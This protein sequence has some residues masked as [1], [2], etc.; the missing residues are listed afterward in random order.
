MTV[1]TE[2]IVSAEDQSKGA[3]DSVRK[4]AGEMAADVRE[5]L[6]TVA[7]SFGAAASA[8]AVAGAAMIK[9]GIDSAREIDNLSRV[10]GA[11]VEEFQRMAFGAKSLGIEQDKLADIIKDTNDKLGDFLTTG[12]GAAAD[13]FENIAPKV[14]VTAEQFRNLSGPDALQLYY[15]SLQKANLSQQELTFYMEAIASDA[16]ALI[17][18]LKDGGEAMGEQAKQA[19][20]LG[21][22]LTKI[23]V[24]KLKQAG[25]AMDQVQAAFGGFGNQIAVKF[26]PVVTALSEK[27]LQVVR[28][29]GGFGEISQKVFNGVISGVGFVADAAH[30][31]KAVWK[32]IEVAVLFAAEQI[33][34]VWAKV[35][36]SIQNVVNGSIDIVNILIEKANMLP[37]VSL[38]TIQKVDSGFVKTLATIKEETAIAAQNARNEVTKILN[39]PMPSEGIKKWTETAVLVST[40]AAKAAADSAASG[41][42]VGGSAPTGGNAQSGDEDPEITAMQQ[43]IEQLK[44]LK[45]AQLASEM[46]SEQLAYLQRLEMLRVNFENNTIPT[47]EQ[48]HALVEGVA[49][50]HEQNLTKISAK[51]LS[52]REKFLAKSGKD[53]TK[54]VFGDLA[55]ITAGVANHNKGLF[56]L[57]KAAGIANA[58]INTYEGVSKSLS[59]YPMPL[60]AVMAAAHL[61]SGMAQVAAIKSTQ[62]GS[63]SAGATSVG[64]AP[65]TTAPSNIAQ[66]A[67]TQEAAQEKPQTV[68]INIE[69]DA[70]YNGRQLRQLMEQLSEQAGFNV[71]FG[72]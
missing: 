38:E 61:A 34:A 51:G 10:A 19:D 58:I 36:Q 62:F 44:I 40:E 67:T 69:P 11:G 32:G 12:G 37:G 57:N 7:L 28:D 14:G 18:L 55:N 23:D 13:F 16:T 1:K 41:S 66:A 43:R 50:K 9:S 56:E 2:F 42:L 20:A 25:G 64:G 3:F 35:A 46:E 5:G 47:L 26:S 53:Q 39:E 30:G 52:D 4:N 24:E 29:M 72:T 15:D 45:D 33:T 6:N 21:I 59:A 49:N 54:Q 27:V 60:A 22:V 71:K 8:A 31:L 65:V 17:P 63:G 68:Y 48:Y 70:N